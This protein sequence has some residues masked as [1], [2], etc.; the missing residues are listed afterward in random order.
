MP[1]C[2]FNVYEL[3]MGRSVSV[4]TAAEILQ[5]CLEL[6]VLTIAFPY[7]HICSVSKNPLWI[8]L[9][10]LH[11][12][13]TLYIGLASIHE[14]QVVYLPDINVLHN[15]THLHLLAAGVASRT[16]PIGFG[17]LSQLTHLSLSW[18]TT[19]SC[20]AGLKS[21][22]EK[23]T[24]VVLILWV[25]V[26]LLPATVE[27]NLRSRGLVDQRLVLLTKEYILEYLEHGGFW[28]H[29]ERVVQWRVKNNSEPTHRSTRPS[30]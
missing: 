20:T 19:R 22:L 9:S 23:E 27:E 13:K 12:L 2:Q 28:T 15:L 25:K 24:A 5:V 21:F 18:S 1:T 30:C 6:T 10:E 14:E 4:P 3:Y 8:P 16:I 17:R 7:H 11:G 26:H 29:A